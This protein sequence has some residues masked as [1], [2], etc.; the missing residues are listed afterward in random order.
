MRNLTALLVLVGILWL[1]GSSLA[2]EVSMQKHTADE[3]K[4][5]CDKVGGRFLQDAGG[6]GCGTN[7]QGG[8]GTDCIVSCKTGQVCFAQTIGSKRPKTLLNALQAQA[9]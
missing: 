6:Y 7:C 3:I 9:R 2:A 8:P 4:S 5:V 1:G